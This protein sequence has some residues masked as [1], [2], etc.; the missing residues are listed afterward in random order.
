M[1]DETS[2]N[3][4]RDNWILGESGLQISAK[5][6]RTRIKWVS[7]LFLSGTRRWDEHLIRHL[8]LIHD[9]EEI[10]KL[11]TLRM[12]EGDIISWQCT[13]RKAVCSR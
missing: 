9:A 4:W 6:N 7:E 12:G 10:L 2:I 8:F 1:A 3:L 5:K 11:R 13:M